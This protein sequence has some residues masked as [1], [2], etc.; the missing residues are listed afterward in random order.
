MFENIKRKTPAHAINFS[1]ECEKLETITR[2]IEAAGLDLTANETDWYKIG[3]AL[4]DLLGE[5]GREYFHRLSRFYGEYSE[6]ETDRKYSA[7]MK[8]QGGS[9]KTTI[10]T[11]YWMAKQAGIDTDTKGT[12]NDRQ[13]VRPLSPMPQ[14]R[15][16]ANERPTPSYL[17]W[18][19]VEPYYGYNRLQYNFLFLWMNHLFGLQ[20]ALRAFEKYLVGSCECAA[21]FFQHD[22]KGWRAMKVQNY[23]P[24]G[25]RDKERPPY[26]KKLSKDFRQV[27]CLFG[28]HL[29]KPD[30]ERVNV[31][32]SEKTAMYCSIWKPD[33]IWLATGGEGKL[34]LPNCE[35]LRGLDVVLYPDLQSE[36]EWEKVGK[37]LETICRSVTMSSICRQFATPD[38]VERKCDLADIIERLL[39]AAKQ[40]EH[41]TPTTQRDEQPAAA[42]VETFFEIIKKSNPLVSQLVNELHLQPDEVER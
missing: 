18:E 29:V 41:P 20:N 14:A 15:P 37:G 9:K 26:Y 39:F 23:L 40:Q 16:A 4:I 13:W 25:H 7:L 32:E 28:S 17:E 33:E 22:G 35:C 34:R 6:A 36:A 1:D 8:E 31:V 27:E 42:A 38:E 24:N 12:L 30:T 21:V 19:A 10:A 5:G 3:F 2:R 11:L